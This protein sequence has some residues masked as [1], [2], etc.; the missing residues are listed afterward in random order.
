MRLLALD[1]V[2]K[3]QRYRLAIVKALVRGRELC[4]RTWWAELDRLSEKD[5]ADLKRLIADERTWLRYSA[6]IGRYPNDIPAPIPYREA[7]R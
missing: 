6:T 4:P 5:Q 1:K 2:P 7:G 3:D